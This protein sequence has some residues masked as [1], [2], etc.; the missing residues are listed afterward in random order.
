MSDIL[1]NPTV[2][3]GEQST[4]PVGIKNENDGS[5]SFNVNV[6]SG[7]VQVKLSGENLRYEKLTE[8]QPL[9]NGSYVTILNAVT[10]QSAKVIWLRSVFSNN[11][12]DIKLTVDSNVVMDG[13]NLNELYSEY[14]MDPSIPGIAELEFIRTEKH[15][16]ILILTFP[17]GMEYNSFFRLE[18]KAL[19]NN[20]SLDRGMYVMSTGI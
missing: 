1:I 4:E 16:K 3:V 7:I 20:Y 10:G 2:I 6:R 13:F 5:T 19:G 8:D 12:I 9:T 14:Y 18:A 15:G 11:N 17:G